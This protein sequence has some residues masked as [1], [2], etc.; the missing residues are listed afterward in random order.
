MTVSEVD[1]EGGDWLT[2]EVSSADILL[3]RSSVATFGASDQS[4]NTSKTG[5]FTV[6]VILMIAVTLN[7]CD[8]N[9]ET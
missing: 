8:P 1:G 7:K 5:V 9:K 6:Q 4:I 2:P 3:V